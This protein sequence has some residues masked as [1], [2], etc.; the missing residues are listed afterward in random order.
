M[1]VHRRPADPILWTTDFSHEEY[2]RWAETR[3]SSTGRLA[4]TGATSVSDVLPPA[5][6]GGS[7]P[8]SRTSKRFGV[9]REPIRG[10]SS[11]RS[12]IALHRFPTPQGDV[13]PAA[14]TRNESQTNRSR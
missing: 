12:S 5:G 13:I 9:V 14:P 3:E 10:E 1:R 8:M 6:L 4:L 7:P 11:F 2:P